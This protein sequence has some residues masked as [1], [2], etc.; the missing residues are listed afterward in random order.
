MLSLMTRVMYLFRYHTIQTSINKTN[1]KDQLS[2]TG[3]YGPYLLIKSLLA[4]RKRPKESVVMFT[5]SN[6][7]TQTSSYDNHS[8]EKKTVSQSSHS[9]QSKVKE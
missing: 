2:L 9:K 6:T 1:L 8:F 7:N 5:I 4:F 3:L